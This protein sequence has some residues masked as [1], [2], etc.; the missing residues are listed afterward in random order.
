MDL[1]HS[2]CTVRIIICLYP[3]YGFLIVHKDKQFDL[4]RI[5]WENRVSSSSEALV[6]ASESSHFAWPVPNSMGS[7]GLQIQAALKSS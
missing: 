6:K 2:P 4:T 7:R 3:N 5:I 1:F